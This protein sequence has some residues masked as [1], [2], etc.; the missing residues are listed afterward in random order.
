MP[1][2]NCA[3]SLTGIVTHMSETP[4]ET[5]YDTDRKR[6]VVI[7]RRDSGSYGYREEYHHKND[8]AEIEGWA[9]LGGRACY[10]EDLETAKRELVEN[11][12]W[13]AERKVGNH[14]AAT[15]PAMTTSCHVQ[16]PVAPVR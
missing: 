3:G 11:V 6:R 7:F 15:K 14:S 2:A 8:L 13:L 1:N 16:S 9:S 12:P 4:V 5:I 10:Y